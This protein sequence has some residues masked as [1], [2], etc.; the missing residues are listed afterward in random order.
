MRRLPT[1]LSVLAGT[2]AL[3]LPAQLSSADT[4]SFKDGKTTDGSMDI[5]RVTVKNEKRLQVRIKVE[6]LK[7]KIGPS[8]GVWLDTDRKH[9]GPDFVIFSGLYQSD[10]QISRSDGWKAVGD[11]LSCAVDQKLGYDDDVISWTTGPKCLGKY[12]QVRVSAEAATE[13]VRDYSPAKHD[14][15]MW[16]DRY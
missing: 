16:V 4:E 11:P 5:H 1:A 8:A 3:L 12:E 13:E 9:R 7:K 6:N 15:H 10:W 14:W 2:A